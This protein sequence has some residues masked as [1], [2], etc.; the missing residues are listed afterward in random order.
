MRG[1]RQCDELSFLHERQHD[2][3]RSYVVVGAP[4]EHFD[5]R[6]RAAL[7]RDV[8]DLQAGQ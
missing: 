3:H 5:G 1:E 4:G 6:F 7:E 2:A 8:H